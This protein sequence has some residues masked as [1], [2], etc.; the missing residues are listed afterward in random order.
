MLGAQTWFVALA[1]P[2]VAV[3]SFI[4]TRKRLS[5]QWKDEL[6]DPNSGVYPT[7]TDAEMAFF[8]RVSSPETIEIESE[9]G[10]VA[11]ST[12]LSRAAKE[13]K[14]SASDNLGW[15]VSYFPDF[16]KIY[17]NVYLDQLKLL[18]Q[19]YGIPWSSKRVASF[20]K[21]VEEEKSLG[22][23]APDSVVVDSYVNNTIISDHPEDAQLLKAPWSCGDSLCIEDLPLV[24]RVLNQQ[25]QKAYPDVGRLR[26]VWIEYAPSGHFFCKPKSPKMFD[27]HDYV[28]VPLTRNFEDS[29]I[30]F[31]PTLRSKFPRIPDIMQHSWTSRD[32]D[33]RIPSGAMLRVYGAARYDWGWAIRPGRKWWGTPT[34]QISGSQT[35][36]VICQ[37]NFYTKLKT[38]FASKGGNTYQVK[39]SDAALVLLHYEGPRAKAKKRSVLLHPEFLIF[40][41]PP[42]VESFET[43]VEDRPSEKYVKEVGL[44]KFLASNYL[45]MFR[46]S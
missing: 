14:L 31:S 26:H 13:H 20:S 16:A 21:R 34:Q 33:A 28:I 15:F 24:L 7:V 37:E 44:I 39:E 38:F 27:G 42:T 43:W 12:G 35:N 17:S 1:V 32:V 2:T 30:T 9:R 29:V 3:G 22:S 23:L 41:R 40:G 11:S 36:P 10:H 6:M 45:T 19:K 25:V 4:A 46:V 8:R 5:Y 18:S